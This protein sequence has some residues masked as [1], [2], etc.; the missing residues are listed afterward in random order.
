MTG[1]SGDPHAVESTLEGAEDYQSPPREPERNEE[2]VEPVAAD[3]RDPID[4][5]LLE[6]QRQKAGLR[7]SETLV[8]D[9]GTKSYTISGRDEESPPGEPDALPPGE[10]M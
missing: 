9:L 3:E 2:G 1:R 4:I 7:P 10:S 8:T 6:S 5:N